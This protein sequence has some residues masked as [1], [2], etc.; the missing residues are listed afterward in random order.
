MSPARFFKRTPERGLVRDRGRADRADAHVGGNAIGRKPEAR[1]HLGIAVD[2]TV[3]GAAGHK[4]VERTRRIGGGAGTPPE[5]VR[6]R[7]VSRPNDGDHERLGE[8]SRDRVGVAR[9]ELTPLAVLAD[10]AAERAQR[11]LAAMRLLQRGNRLSIT[12]VD[13]REWAF[14]TTKLAR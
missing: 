13:P 12:P 2:P 1:Q 14:I 10:E 11:E 9:G 7:I 4:S 3:V 8:R 6:D 5:R